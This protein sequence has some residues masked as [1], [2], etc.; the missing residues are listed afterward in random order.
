MTFNFFPFETG[1]SFS[2][3]EMHLGFN[4]ISAEEDGTGDELTIYNNNNFIHSYIYSC[5]VGSRD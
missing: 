4:A 5:I 3:L 1:T 2:E